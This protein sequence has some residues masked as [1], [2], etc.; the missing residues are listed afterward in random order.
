VLTVRVD[1]PNPVT[2]VGLNVVVVP[3]GAP[4]TLRLTIP[5]NPFSAPIVAV[6]V[7]ELPCKTVLELGDAD[8]VKSGAVKTDRLSKFVF[9]PLLL[10]SVTVAHGLVHPVLMVA[11]VP[12]VTAVVTVVWPLQLIVTVLLPV[13]PL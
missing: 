11:T 5:P 1:V 12:A 4:V 3:V 6:Y 7:V 9:Q 13:P 2:D 10:A 8:T